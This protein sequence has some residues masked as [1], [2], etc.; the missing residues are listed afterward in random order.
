MKIIIT[1]IIFLSMKAASLCAD[2]LSA[3]EIDQLIAGYR[4]V[5]TK[6]NNPTTQLASAL[7]AF[8]QSN[9]YKLFID[10][11]RLLAPSAE[12][13][14]APP[15]LLFDVK[16]PGYFSGMNDALKQLPKF[17]GKPLT[18][19][20]ALELHDV[21]MKDIAHATLGV[22]SSDYFYTT[23][24]NDEALDEM[25]NSRLLFESRR[26]LEALSEQKLYG[27]TAILQN[28]AQ[29]IPE[30]NTFLAYAP[31]S[32]KVEV[33]STGVTDLATKIKPYL[34]HYYQSV[35]NAP[36]LNT[37]LMAIADLIRVLEAAHYFPDGNTRTNLFLILP[38]L[39]IENGLPP[40]ILKN[41]GYFNGSHTLVQMA[42]SLR[43]GIAN[44]L[45]EDANAQRSWL[46]EH[47][48]QNPLAEDWLHAPSQCA[49]SS[50]IFP[51]HRLKRG[52]SKFKIA[53]YGGLF[54][55]HALCRITLKA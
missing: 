12:E 11:N 46:M 34:D 44:F 14:H 35:H 52:T 27:K 55:C 33:K 36:N 32:E 2:N 21:A 39:M 26:F 37:I 20:M 47:A 31:E 43:E 5:L 48:C 24:K 28:Y 1:I 41:P 45:N 18:L 16:E 6:T 49:L 50:S 53:C 15:H 54:F 19:D 51:T 30:K 38:K 25:F 7:Q 10:Q 29:H 13:K 22:F 8:P 9:L 4:S 17:L 40:V 23:V 42:R 3:Q